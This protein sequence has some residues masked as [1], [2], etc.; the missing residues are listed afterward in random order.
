MVDF[1]YAALP[2]KLAAADVRRLQLI[3]FML[4]PPCVGCHGSGIQGANVIA[5]K[6]LTI[7]PL[8]CNAD[9]L[10]GTGGATGETGRSGDRRYHPVRIEIRLKP[11]RTGVRRSARPGLSGTVSTCAELGGDARLRFR[12][13]CDRR[14]TDLFKDVV[15]DPAG[16]Q[17]LAV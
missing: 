5:V 2:I 12:F 8:N 3:H 10:I 11:G 7:H 9:L 15:H 1:R 4:E 16:Q 17:N 13:N 6:S 14:R